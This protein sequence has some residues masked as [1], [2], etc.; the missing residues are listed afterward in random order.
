[1]GLDQLGVLTVGTPVPKV[2]GHTLLHSILL[3]VPPW[4]RKP[5]LIPVRKS[6]FGML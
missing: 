3:V 2:G 5:R 1:M 6:A 4:S